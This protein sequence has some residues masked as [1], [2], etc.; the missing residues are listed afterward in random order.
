MSKESENLIECEG[1]VIALLPNATFRVEL[2][3]GRL[4]IA[5]TSGRMRKSRVRVLVGD[6]VTLQVSKYDLTK[7][8][9][10][11]RHKTLPPQPPSDSTSSQ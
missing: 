6:K 11:R 7:G 3:N 5:H 2:D 4:L 1:K 10:V 9:V 8:R